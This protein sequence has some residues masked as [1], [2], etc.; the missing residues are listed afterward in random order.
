MF[1]SCFSSEVV[2]AT[3]TERQEALHYSLDKIH[4]VKKMPTIDTFRTIL[5]KGI[6]IYWLLHKES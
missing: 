1:M 3:I 5:Q 2:S 6:I 4:L